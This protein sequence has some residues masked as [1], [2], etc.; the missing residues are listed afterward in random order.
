[1]RKNW[2]ILA[3][4]VV[5]ALVSTVGA[6]PITFDKS[7]EVTV[8]YLGGDAGFS[9]YFGWVSGTP[10][11]G[12]LHQLGQGHVTPTGSI[13]PIGVRA[14]NENNILYIKTDENNVFYS[15]PKTA[16]PDGIEHVQV[17]PIDPNAYILKCGFED[18]LNG[19]DRD[20]ND[21]YLQVSC[22][23]IINPPPPVPEF[24]TMAFPV[25]LIIGMLGA[26]LFIQ[27]SKEQ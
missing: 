6:V 23:P 12:T 5:F 8:T 27:K 19:G 4:L 21:I 15:D 2:I 26:V 3:V 11:S 18:L 9:N 25:A 20:F 22:D 24:P 7:C 17:V 1:M 13:F 14:A 10:P 16:N